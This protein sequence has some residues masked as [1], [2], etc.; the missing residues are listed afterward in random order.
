[1]WMIDSQLSMW[2]ALSL[3]LI[4]LIVSAIYPLPRP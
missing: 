3:R 2:P 1:V 4:F